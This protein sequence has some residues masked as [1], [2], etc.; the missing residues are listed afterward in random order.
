MEIEAEAGDFRHE[1][2]P[3]GAKHEE[4]YKD[5]LPQNEMAKTNRKSTEK[6]ICLPLCLLNGVVEASSLYWVVCNGIGWCE[7]V[8]PW[9]SLDKATKT[10]KRNRKKAFKV[11]AEKELALVA[12]L[13]CEAHQIWLKY[14]M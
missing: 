2:D 12:T 4:R 5:G 6:K 11:L 13:H 8:V 1:G 14:E 9:P 10:T 7:V 3:S